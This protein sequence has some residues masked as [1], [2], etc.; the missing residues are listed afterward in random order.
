MKRAR[1]A[2]GPAGISP[3]SRAISG[4]TSHERAVSFRRFWKVDSGPRA[5]RITYNSFII[6]FMDGLEEVFVP[7]GR[8]VRPGERKTGRTQIF[9]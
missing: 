3:D 5:R 2:S 9:S 6:N 8:D 4:L 7:M 1:A